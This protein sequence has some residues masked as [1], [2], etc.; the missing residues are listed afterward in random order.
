MDEPKGKEPNKASEIQWKD[1][2]R[3]GGAKIIYKR[4]Q[5]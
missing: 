5:C 2:K 3:G 4:L 1:E